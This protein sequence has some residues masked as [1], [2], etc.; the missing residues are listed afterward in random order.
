MFTGERIMKLKEAVSKRITELCKE[1]NI[2]P[3]KLAET[4][5]VP[6]STLRDMINCRTENPS[7]LVIFQLC[8]ALNISLENFFDNEIFNNNNIE[9]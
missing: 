4:S 7:A 8:R 2:T 3:N 6:T 1:R 5:T 9:D